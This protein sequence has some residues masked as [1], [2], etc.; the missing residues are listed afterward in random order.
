MWKEIVA[1]K[2][3]FKEMS[4]VTKIDLGKLRCEISGTT[5]E[6]A[7]A[8]NGV[9]VNMRNANKMDVRFF[10]KD[11]F[12]IDFL[13]HFFR[14]LNIINSIVKLMISKDNCQHLKYN[15]KAH[16]M[17]SFNAINAYSK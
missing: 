17:K 4:S 8:C 16:A 7:S 1:V 12:E 11:N 3:M 13:N 5:R 15:M 14:K 6:V 2:R 9:S 10:L